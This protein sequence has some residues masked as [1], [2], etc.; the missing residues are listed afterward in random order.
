MS[1]GPS[2]RYQS[3]LFNF[4][5]KRSRRFAEQWN[6]SLRNLQVTTQWNVEAFI[7]S[8]FQLF[9]PTLE[10][11]RELQGSEPQG[12]RNLPPNDTDSLRSTTASVDTPINRVLEIVSNPPDLVKN[13]SGTKSSPNQYISGSD[14]QGIATELSSKQLVLVTAENE[15]IDVL[16]PQQQEKLQNQIAEEISNY[17]HSQ[18]LLKLQKE[19]ELLP[20]INRLLTKLTNGQVPTEETV[21]D[22]TSSTYVLEL[23]DAAVAKLESNAVNPLSRAI[24]S[25]KQRSQEVIQAA[26]TQLNI[27]VYGKEELAGRGQIVLADDTPKTPVDS[28]K[29]V[30]GA[31]FNFLFGE[32]PTNS[33]QTTGKRLPQNQASSQNRDLPNQDTGVDDWLTWSD[34][35]GNSPRL[36][37]DSG[38]SLSSNL[39]NSYQKFLRQPGSEIVQRPKP[40]GNIASKN[41]TESRIVQPESQNRKGNI[42]QQRRQS[43]QVEAQRDWI[44]TEATPLGYEQHPLEL[45]LEWL[46]R[47]MLW[48]EEILVKIFMRLQRLWRG[49]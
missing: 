42:T 25:L 47:A 30:V 36:K 13:N 43:S 14:I 35:F 4:L 20:E 2:G 22:A 49:K 5:H 24:E 39:V 10:V 19:R 11:G 15:I 27:F 17:W 44:E 45:L 40:S 9:Q 34:L 8:L 31:V 41:K 21:T 1:S 29:A 26:Q 16:P 48:L 37:P 18:N 7:Y 33:S 23:V 12:R 38:K 6:N 46:D 32:H 3:R 28:L